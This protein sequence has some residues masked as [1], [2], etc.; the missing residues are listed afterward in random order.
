MIKLLFI[1]VDGTLT[2]GKIYMGVDG[3]LCKVF[4]VKDGCAIHDILPQYGIVPVIITGRTSKIV[5]NRAVE[6]GI[7]ETY[8]GVR[9]K[10]A[11]VLEIMK[12]Y[13]CPPHAAAYIGDDIIDLPC[14]QLCGVSGCPSDAV[15]AV[16]SVCDYI[17]KLPGGKGA[18][19]EFIE[20]LIR[21]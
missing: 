8:Q 6:L 19:R 9:D 14:M 13:G 1:D 21:E 2:D 10:A 17:C 3:E 15:T 7:A 11:L 5:E 18:V 20:W 4:D 12:K 16:K